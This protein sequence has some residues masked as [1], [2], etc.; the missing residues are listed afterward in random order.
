MHNMRNPVGKYEAAF[1]Q[2]APYAAIPVAVAYELGWGFYHGIPLVMMTMDFSRAAVAVTLCAIVISVMFITTEF[3]LRVARFI[4]REL[5]WGIPRYL[6]IALGIYLIVFY[7]AVLLSGISESIAFAML[8][9]GYIPIIFFSIMGAV[10]SKK[11]G[12]SLWGG[13]LLKLSVTKDEE[14]EKDGAFLNLIVILSASCAFSFSVGVNMAKWTDNY[15]F[16]GNG[17]VIG[18]YHDYFLVKKDS[19]FDLVKPLQAH[20]EKDKKK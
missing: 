12:G 13:F 9:Y 15:S 19:G 1:I 4:G 16:S 11:D 20:L 17:R 14:V 7:L 10:I 2:C 18:T 5:L 3:S 8:E 6:A